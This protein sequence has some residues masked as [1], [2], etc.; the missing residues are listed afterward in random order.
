MADYDYRE[1][2][3]DDI[4]DVVD[5]YISNLSEEDIANYREDADEFIQYLNDEL[6]VD[7]SV[8]GNGSGSYTTDS[9][10]AKQYVMENMDL[11]VDA[12]DEF[13]GDFKYLRNKDWESID[14]TIRC[15]LLGQVLWD[16]QDEL[17][18]KLGG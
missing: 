5:D 13:G 6:W 1:A 8:T 12:E 17:V 14:V 10:T 3:H 16:M 15:Y 18:A 11:Y 2:L 9:E 4:L 7:D